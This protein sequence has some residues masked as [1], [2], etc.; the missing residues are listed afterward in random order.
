MKPLGWLVCCVLLSPSLAFGQAKE[1][2]KSEPPWYLKPVVRP[3]IPGT[4]RNPIDAFLGA[5]HQVK[6]LKPVDPA[7]RRTLLRRLYLDLIGIPPTVAE[8]DAFLADK[9]PD[10]Y[11]KIVDRLLANEQHGV[12]YA[13]H[14]LDVL[15]YADT[16]DGM[17][18]APGIH[19]WREWVI[20]ALNADMPFDQFVCTQ[21]TGY[22][23]SARSEISAVGFRERIDPRPDDVFALGFL[24]RGATPDDAELAINAVETASSAFLGLTVGCAK[25]HDHEYD[26]ITQR[27]F[28]RM[29]A[30]FDPLAVKKVA[31]AS[32]AEMFAQGQKI[33]G[34]NKQLAPVEVSI[35]T[36]IAPYKKKLFNERVAQLPPDV[37]TVILKPEK[38]RT[39]AEEKI[40]DDYFPILR[41]DV[42][43]IMLIMPEAEKEKYAALVKEFRALEKAR[44]DAAL[45]SFWTV[46]VDRKREL[47]KSF[48]LTSGDPK[49]PQLKKPVSPGW[50]FAP[51]K[52]DFRVGRV[53]AFADWLTAAENQLFAR[54]AVNRLWQ[55]HFGIGLQKNP[56][57]FGKLGGAPSH[58]Q[59]LDWLAAEFAERK[60]SMKA[61]HRLIVTSEAYKRSS[62]GREDNRKLDSSNTY[63][64]RY[65]L[66][67][68]DAETVWDSIHAAAGTLDIKVG[69]KSFDPKTDAPRRG[70][71][72]TRGYASNR[73]VMPAFLQAFDAEDG[74]A[75][76]AMRTHTVTAPQ[77]LF[78]MNSDVIDAATTKFAERLKKAA[79][80]D[81]QAAVEL[82]YRSALTRP[83]TAAETE[84]AL[85]YLDGD[86][87]RL[88]GFAWMLF[89]LDEFAFVR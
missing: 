29:K 5:A 2:P 82:G 53:D 67:R 22:R 4:A 55:W 78:L 87:E 13:R 84:R 42:G 26:P 61:M 57:D 12:R 77:A 44:N 49:R 79:G 39:P 73:E 38:E 34:I 80:N 70:A 16:D 56:S 31:L 14:W 72:I 88:R 85:A 45:P 18:A 23:T 75:P 74:R 17:I 89:N 15:R 30:L 52:I 86:P 3:A 71:Y 32:A 35:Q 51:A 46:E 59:L 1:K 27:D 60:F 47:D 11:E 69:G 66:R 50:P 20:R 62:E 19:L 65:P 76:C 24:S 43:K 8:Q 58:P 33:D 81:L 28:Y 6:G 7:D 63:L 9:T 37:R 21:L 48:I 10:A 54:V 40:A 25:C 83:P 64:W 68:L 36:L 41:I